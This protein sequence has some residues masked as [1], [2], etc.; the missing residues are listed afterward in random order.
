MLQA[1]L[2]VQFL[3]WKSHLES[4]SLGCASS[5]KKRRGG[6]S[7]GGFRESRGSGVHGD[8]SGE[9]LGASGPP[10]VGVPRAGSAAARIQVHLGGGKLAG[11]Q[12][13]GGGRRGAHGSAPGRGPWPHHK[14]RGLAADSEVALAT[15]K[16]PQAE[17][18]QPPH[19]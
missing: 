9:D 18:T 13:E 12:P 19:T 1:A 10:G 11:P 17:H 16:T 14:A 2:A 7:G 15:F 6:A 8:S 5:R 4:Y 3:V